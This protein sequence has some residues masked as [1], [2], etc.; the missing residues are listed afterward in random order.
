M[1]KSDTYVGIGILTK[2]FKYQILSL[3]IICPF[4]RLCCIYGVEDINY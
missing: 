2:A 4:S 1:I 3:V